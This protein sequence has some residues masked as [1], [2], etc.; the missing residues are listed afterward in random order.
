MGQFYHCD[1]LAALFQMTALPYLLAGLWK[2]ERHLGKWGILARSHQSHCLAP[3]TPNFPWEG[4]SLELIAPPEG[5]KI[6]ATYCPRISPRRREMKSGRPRIHMSKGGQK[7]ETPI[8]LAHKMAS[9]YYLGVTTITPNNEI[10]A[11]WCTEP[12]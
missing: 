1:F 11:L 4:Q 12:C 10:L 5:K 3:F 8:S 9:V 6:K 2:Q 7:H